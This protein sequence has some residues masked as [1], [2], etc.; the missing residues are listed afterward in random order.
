MKSDASKFNTGNFETGCFYIYHLFSCSGGVVLTRVHSFCCR[1]GDTAYALAFREKQL[2][3]M[4]VIEQH[5]LRNTLT[6]M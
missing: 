5:T 4:R 2:R 1:R 6:K 3:V